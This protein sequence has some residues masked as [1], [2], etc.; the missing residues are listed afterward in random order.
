MVALSLFL[1]GGAGLRAVASGEDARV[2]SHAYVVRSGDTL[3]DIAQAEAG[4]G[5]PRPLVDAIVAV[6][7]LDDA[8]VRPGQRLLVPASG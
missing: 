2:S 3:W 4:G 5:D 7:A 6:N 1:V 8:T